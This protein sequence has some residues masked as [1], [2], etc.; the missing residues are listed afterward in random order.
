MIQEDVSD[1]V[2]WSFC[3]K[4]LFSVSSYRRCVEDLVEEHATVWHGNS[5]PKV[6]IFVWQLLRG[7]IMVW[8]ILNRFGVITN[9]DLFCPLCERAVESM[10]H[11]FL[12]CPWSWSLWTSCMGWWKV[13]CCANRSINEWFTG[14]QRLSPSPKMGRAWVM[15]FYAAVWSIWW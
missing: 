15:L 2:A 1:S 11:L 3:S 7:R 12:L 6:E 14:W 8:D 13:N 9:D 10:D 4:G 5:P